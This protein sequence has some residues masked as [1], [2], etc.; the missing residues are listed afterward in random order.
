MK[1]QHA[2]LLGI[3]LLATTLAGCHA[4]K[5]ETVPVKSGQEAGSPEIMRV[6]TGYQPCQP[7]TN[8]PVTLSNGN[9]ILTAVDLAF[10]SRGMGVV[11]HRTYISP[12]QTDTEILAVMAD[13]ISAGVGQ[14]Y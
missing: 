10:P 1:K 5:P 9:L 7:S 6:S 4:R 11:F 13:N 2:L 3:A 14:R 8:L 12:R